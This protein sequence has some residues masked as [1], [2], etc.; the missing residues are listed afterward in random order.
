MYLKMIASHCSF[1]GVYGYVYV[2]P[3]PLAACGRVWTWG[4]STIHHT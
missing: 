4:I 3:P 1:R 2:L